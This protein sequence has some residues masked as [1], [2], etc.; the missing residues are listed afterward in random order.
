MLLLN[1]G[2]FYSQT[3]QL[4]LSTVHIKADFWNFEIYLQVKKKEKKTIVA[5]GQIKKTHKY[6]ENG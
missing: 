3:L 6:L 4:F 5:N 1:L 2:F